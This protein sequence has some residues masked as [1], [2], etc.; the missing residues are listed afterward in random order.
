M[1]SVDVRKI[2]ATERI[3]QVL[4]EEHCILQAGVTILGERIVDS[5]VVVIAL[6]EPKS[7]G[8]EPTPPAAPLVEEAPAEQPKP[9]EESPSA[10][11]GQLPEQLEGGT[12]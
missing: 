6:P 12:N 11:S 1:D 10:G 8:T 9:E 3:K 2:R 5:Q 4:T 7:D